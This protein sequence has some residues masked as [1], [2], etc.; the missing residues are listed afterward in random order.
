MPSLGSHMRRARLVAERLR[1]PEIDVDRGSYYLGCAAPDIRVITRRDRIVT[2][3]FALDEFE[4][5]DSVA[6]MFEENPQ[7]ARPAGLDAATTAFLAGYLTHLVMDERFIEEVYRPHFGAHSELDKDPRANVLDRALQY[8]M[9]RRDREDRDAME[10]IQSAL[11]ESAASEGAPEPPVA[12]IPFIE[13]E[14]LVQWAAVCEDVAG[15]PPDYSR[16]RRM[17]SRH[18]ELAGFDDTQ[19]EQWA[20][21]P[22]SL[23]REAFDIVSEERVDRFWHDVEDRMTERVRSYLR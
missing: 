20:D 22:H 3:F 1:L 7:L 8:E 9:D 19:I 16:F 18:M 15:Q 13:D 17:M 11:A 5:Q 6:R 2:H 10:E 14:H 23:V 12:G 21:E 4:P